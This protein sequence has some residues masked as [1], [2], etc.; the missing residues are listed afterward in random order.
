MLKINSHLILLSLFLQWSRNYVENALRQYIS[1]RLSVKKYALPPMTMI[2][3]MW[4]RKWR[5][6]I[7]FH[8]QHMLYENPLRAHHIIHRD[9]SIADR[10]VIN[11]CRVIVKVRVHFW[12]NMYTN[13]P[14]RHIR[15]IE[16]SLRIQTTVTRNPST[17]VAFIWFIKKKLNHAEHQAVGLDCEYRY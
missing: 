8:H 15:I 13:L 5:F 11:L 6:Q 7:R 2:L 17:V 16:G 4:I 9:I 1:A 10:M 12:K 3:V 14:D